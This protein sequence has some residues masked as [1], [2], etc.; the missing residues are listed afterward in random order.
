MGSL[1][2]RSF[3]EGAGIAARARRLPIAFR[4]DS[5]QLV[6]L[7]FKG[8][9]LNSQAGNKFC[10]IEEVALINISFIEAEVVAILLFPKRFVRG[11]GRIFRR[12]GK[13]RH[14]KFC[15]PKRSILVEG[16]HK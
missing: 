13:I 11:F 15:G 1:G 10:R 2:C 5:S 14:V 4:Y 8:N 9:S 7:R 16:Q 12:F 6:G 3:D